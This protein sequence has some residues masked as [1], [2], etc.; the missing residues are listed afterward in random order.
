MGGERGLTQY[1]TSRSNAC[2]APRL[3]VVAPSGRNEMVFT[4]SFSFSF[5]FLANHGLEVKVGL[6]KLLTAFADGR[7]HTGVLCSRTKCT[8]STKRS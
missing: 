4:V 1:R 8:K 6:C 5:L 3:K 7:R 2:A